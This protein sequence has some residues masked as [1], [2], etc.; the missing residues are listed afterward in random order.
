M[1]CHCVCDVG[2]SAC[3]CT[4]LHLPF[5]FHCFP[6]VAVVLPAPLPVPTIGLT[7]C[8]SDP[9]PSSLHQNMLPFMLV[10]P[11][12]ALNPWCPLESFPFGFK[13]PLAVPVLKKKTPLDLPILHKLFKTLLWYF[14]CQHFYSISR[15]VGVTKGKSI[16]Q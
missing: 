6:H 7:Y 15:R 14:F 12:N 11:S 9:V 5:S 2:A 3:C 10:T 1:H 16:S 8:P 13:C 4:S